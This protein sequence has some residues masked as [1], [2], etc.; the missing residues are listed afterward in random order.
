MHVAGQTIQLSNDD[1]AFELA[2]LGERGGELRATIQRVR[3]L[4]GFDLYKLG[5]DLQ[6]LGRGEPGEGFPLCGQ[7]KAR[8]ALLRGADPNVADDL[9]GYG[10]LPRRCKDTIRMFRLFTIVY[11]GRS[12]A[13]QPVASPNG[14]ACHRG[15][16]LVTGRSI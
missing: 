9:L 2:G 3:S 8:L 15:A 16:S 4:A 13:G 12:R 6:T 5:G 10:A 11:L 7:A 14:E 1:R